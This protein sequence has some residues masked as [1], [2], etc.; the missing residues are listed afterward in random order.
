MRS[1]TGKRPRG[2][3]MKPGRLSEEAVGAVGAS[4]IPNTMVPYS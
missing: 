2:K 1:C 3:I 4:R